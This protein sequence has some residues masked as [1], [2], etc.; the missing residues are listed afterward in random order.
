MRVASDQNST[1][2]QED[3]SYLGGLDMSLRD[4]GVVREMLPGLTPDKTMTSKGLIGVISKLEAMR[5]M[6]G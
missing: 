2:P 6:L 1:L 3:R 5:K 4:T